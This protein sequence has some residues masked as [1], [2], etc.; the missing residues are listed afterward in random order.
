MT[1]RDSAPDTTELELRA[2]VAREHL[3]DSIAQLDRRAK[4]IAHTAADAGTASGFGAAAAVTLWLSW[5]ILR[6]AVRPKSAPEYVYDAPVRTRPSIFSRVLRVAFATA[7]FVAT[8]VLVYVAERRARNGAQAPLL[9]AEIIQRPA[10]EA[11]D[12]HVS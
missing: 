9:P 3:M 7:G 12:S 1:E 6:G 5:S 8:G 2:R 11:L 10:P 4:R